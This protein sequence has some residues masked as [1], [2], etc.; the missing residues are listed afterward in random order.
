MV[1]SLPSEVVDAASA[2]LLATVADLPDTDWSGDTHC[3]G[4]SRAHVIAHLVLNAEGLAGVLD[5]LRAG[6]PRT[7]YASDERRDADIEELAAA[8]P[9]EIRARLR[10]AV[11][12]FG[13]AWSGASVP[14]EQFERTPGGQLIRAAAIGFMR[15]REVEIHHADLRAGYSWS[16]WP[17]QT[18]AAFLDNSAK[19]Y[20][21]PGFR[22]ATDGGG[23][24][25]FGDPDDDAPTVTGPAGAVAWWATGRPVDDDQAGPVLSSTE[26]TLPTMEG[27]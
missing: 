22:V 26:G 25:A 18:V 27:R 2:R 20:D 11:D 1:S 15:L 9:D 21:G 5:G 14:G 6:E 19:Q 16:D 8:P 4:W 13:A 17:E 23:T 10:A 3:A 7:M 12:R 24:W